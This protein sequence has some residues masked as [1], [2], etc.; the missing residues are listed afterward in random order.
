MRQRDL[1]VQLAEIERRRLEGKLSH[2]EAILARQNL[3]RDNKSKVQDMKKEV[4]HMLH[5]VSCQTLNSPPNH[6]SIM[7]L[8]SNVMLINIFYDMMN[9]F[10]KFVVLKLFKTILTFE[11]LT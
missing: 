7:S 2:E 6:F 11:H 4:G 3:I 1:E 5:F 10:L 8:H 9:M